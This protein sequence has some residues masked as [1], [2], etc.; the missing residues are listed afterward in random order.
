MI[1]FSTSLHYIYVL[2]LV[3]AEATRKIC[4][5]GTQG[6][7]SDKVSYPAGELAVETPTVDACAFD[8]SCSSD[9]VCSRIALFANYLLSYLIKSMMYLGWVIKRVRDEIDQRP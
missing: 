9:Y 2:L 5:R 4:V 8:I 1:L 7:R 6:S 3:K